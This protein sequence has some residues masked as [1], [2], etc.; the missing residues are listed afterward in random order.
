MII[1]VGIESERDWVLEK[2]PYT[3]QVIG[4]GGY[5]V[6]A[7]EGES[8]IGFAWCFMRKVQAPVE[9]NE[10]FINVIEV[11]DERN[12]CKDVASLIVNKC[13][14]IAKEKGCYQI[15][16]YCDKSNVSSH[17]LWEKNKFAISPV[18]MPDRGIVGSYV[19]RVL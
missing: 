1:R 13:I 6:V 15:R 17:K 10:A 19:A 3:A 9:V 16:A 2:Y 4:E 18:A 14:E 5:M 12:R 11:F 8:I 7:V